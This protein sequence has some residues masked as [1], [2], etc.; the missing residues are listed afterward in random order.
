MRRRWNPVAPEPAVASW[1]SRA[2]ALAWLTVLVV[3]ALALR[4]AAPAGQYA[5]VLRPERGTVATFG[6]T[7]LALR[8][9]AQAVP[10]S[11]VT[12]SDT[13]RA[14]LRASRSD[15]ELRVIPG[16]PT[17][18]FALI[19]RLAGRRAN[20]VVL[21]Q[22]GREFVCTRHLVASALRLRTPSVRLRDAF[23]AAASAAAGATNDTL[24]MRCVHGGSHVLLVRD[25]ETSPLRDSLRLSP[26]LGWALF[27]PSR[28]VAGD[29]SVAVRNFLWLL[30]LAVPPGYWLA[31]HGAA[32][33]GHG[34]SRS[35]ARRSLLAAA[36]AVVAAQMV[37]WWL[38]TRALPP[39][40]ELLA[41]V[42]GLA[43]GA[44]AAHL[45]RDTHTH[46]FHE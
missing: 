6:G 2:G 5:V 13:I 19:V 38:A 35:T 8:V 43:A 21:G 41:S 1:L 39:S 20:A 40:S 31:W 22:H 15:V 14:V 12:D 45:K 36:F 28:L 9:G 34:T 4:A 30:A 33:S 11:T 10:L 7:V 23:P 37:V 46:S 32:R 42:V 16:P 29:R 3:S 27:L 44:A 18:S 26:G 17:A 24:T 25:G